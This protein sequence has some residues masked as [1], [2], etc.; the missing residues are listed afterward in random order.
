MGVLVEQVPGSYSPGANL[1]PPSLLL[2]A[3]GMGTYS[4][5]SNPITRLGTPDLMQ[6]ELPRGLFQGFV[7]AQSRFEGTRGVHGDNQKAEPQVR[8]RYRTMKGELETS[9]K[10]QCLSNA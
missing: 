5:A 6:G 4:S 3:T 1:L 8:G 9:R 2:A 7:L 10:A